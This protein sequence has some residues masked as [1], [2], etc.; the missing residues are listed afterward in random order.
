MFFAAL[1]DLYRCGFAVFVTL[2]LALVAFAAFVAMVA[3]VAVLALVRKMSLSHL[4]L[5]RSD[6]LTSIVC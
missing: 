6:L 4:G 2:V 1:V 3:L 5:R